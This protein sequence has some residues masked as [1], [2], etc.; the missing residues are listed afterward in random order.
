MTLVS[1]A[2]A[3]LPSERITGEWSALAGG[4]PG[5][6]GSVHEV[7]WNGAELWAIGE[8]SHIATVSLPGIGRRDAN[9]VWSLPG[10]ETWI[11]PASGSSRVSPTKLHI[12]GD[13]KIWTIS[14][15]GYVRTQPVIRCF[16]GSR[17]I[18]KPTGAKAPTNF[19]WSFEGISTDRSN[20][21]LVWGTFK[22]GSGDTAKFRLI[23]EEAGVWK[24]LAYPGPRNTTMTPLSLGGDSLS[25]GSWILSG[26][27]W[28]PSPD[29]GIDSFEI[30][31]EIRMKDGSRLAYLRDVDPEPELVGSLVRWDGSGWKEFMPDHPLRVL[32]PV[33][34]G[35]DP[36]GKVL[37]SGI[38]KDRFRLVRESSTGWE[39]L[40]AMG[41]RLL[42][43]AIHGFDMAASGE[44]AIGGQFTLVDS[45]PAL[46]LAIR[47]AKEWTS[48]GTGFAGTLRAA[49]VDK[50]GGIVVGGL[51]SGV[52]GRKMSNIARY[53]DGKWQPMGGG[54]N[55]VVFGLATTP[56][57]DVVAAG[58]F[59]TVDGRTPARVARWD[60]TSWQAVGAASYDGDILALSSDPQG[61]IWTSLEPRYA[62]VDRWDG[63]SS[64]SL[65]SGTHSDRF[66]A[67]MSFAPDGSAFLGGHE[68]GGFRTWRVSNTSETSEWYKATPP[69]NL[70]VE[71]STW[72]R[73]S[74]F[75]LAGTFTETGFCPLAL[76]GS[77]N[78]SPLGC[79]FKGVAR[80]IGHGA[81]DDIFLAGTMQHGSLARRDNL[82]RWDG[83][84]MAAID[85][86]EGDA[87]VVVRDSTGSPVVI[88]DLDNS[89]GSSVFRL[90]NPGATGIVPRE[91]APANR[92]L[93]RTGAGLVAGN[94][95]RLEIFDPT[96]K[97]E[98][99]GDVEA[100]FALSTLPLGGG[101]H[102]ARLGGRT[103]RFCGSTR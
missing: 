25:F 80:S 5:A 75:A 22:F 30:V 85:G 54:A 14:D 33:R 2:A 15:S 86:L 18:S 72:I 79:E 34:L 49:T 90:R 3:E 87:L 35:I 60:G 59:D 45:F 12:G 1:L 99:R 61:R 19:D 43:D 64:T 83:A 93:L 57:G 63:S 13:G 95:G 101:F 36:S 10:S 40:A 53:H 102:L 78:L 50:D 7:R 29:T 27:T 44:L 39:D 51:F 71:S 65:M 37:V 69:T 98:W 74:V 67:T 42:D 6:D 84:R 48:P 82:L 11:V 92:A 17:W 52:D 38:F 81:R 55:D 24:D 41:P 21:P 23:R 32:D 88:G 4:H 68:Y 31:A 103:E 46:N 47:S 66:V 77:Q 97:L 73:D 76:T 96:G 94:P 70:E 91:K 16:D 89:E 26:S 8:F 20:A 100:G 58:R 62:A 9:G 56:A 28:S